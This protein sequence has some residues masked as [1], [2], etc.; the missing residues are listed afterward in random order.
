[1]FEDVTWDGRR[2]KWDLS[3]NYGRQAALRKAVEKNLL[4][5]L[6]Q[7][8]VTHAGLIISKSTD[9]IGSFYAQCWAF[10]R[11]LW[12]YNNGQYRPALQQML[13]DAAEGNLYR[14][15]IPRAAGNQWDTRSAKQM[16]EHYLQTDLATID[17]EY[18]HYMLEL[19]KSE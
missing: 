6:D 2:P 15:G 8:A 12:Q 13:T 5:P 17:A 3:V 10:A 16:L 11:F 19:V 18:Q 14:G 9:Q 7:L 1:M 4:L